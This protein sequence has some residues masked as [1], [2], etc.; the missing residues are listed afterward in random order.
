[1][2]GYIFR[3]YKHGLF[4]LDC[5]V[6]LSTD[7]LLYIS[8]SLDQHTAVIEILNINN[9][10]FSADAKIIHQVYQAFDDLYTNEHDGA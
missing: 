1:M 2:G 3:E 5:R 4:N 6:I 10:D 7:F 8:H 9:K